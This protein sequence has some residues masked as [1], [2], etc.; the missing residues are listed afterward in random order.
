MTRGLV[1][2]LLATILIYLLKYDKFVLDP[3][4]FY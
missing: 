2:E 1:F 3:S 4:V